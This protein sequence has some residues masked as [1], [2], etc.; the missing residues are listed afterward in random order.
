M[1]AITRAIMAVLIDYKIAGQIFHT[2]VIA[3]VPHLQTPN[4]WSVVWW[5]ATETSHASAILAWTLVQGSG[6]FLDYRGF[7]SGM[8]TLSD[9]EASV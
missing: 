8:C 2:P 3:A 4:W 1:R 7:L 5:G 6:S 9:D